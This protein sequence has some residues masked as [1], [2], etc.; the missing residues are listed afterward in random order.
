MEHREM[1]HQRLQEILG[2]DFH[3]QF[4]TVTEYR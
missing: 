2:P 1:E 3:K 4:E